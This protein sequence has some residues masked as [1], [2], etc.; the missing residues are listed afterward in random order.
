MKKFLLSLAFC[1]SLPACA[2]ELANADAL[3][4]RKAYP[5]AMRLYTKLGNAGNPVAQLRLGELYLNANAGSVDE[6]KAAQ[7]LSKAATKGNADAGAALA[8]LKTR[9]ARRADIDYWTAKYDG[10]DIVAG[11]PVCRVPR[12]PAMS[13]QNEEI[14]RIGAA[15]EKWQACYNTYA[16][17]LNDAGPLGKRMPADIAALLS[18]GEMAQAE[19]RYTSTIQTMQEDARVSA[20]LALADIAAWRS[21]TNAYVAEHNAIV[22]SGPSPERIRELEARK[23]NYASGGK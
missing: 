6:D 23:A 18:P 14:D 5:E 17:R 13:K 16:A 8:R 7:W 19:T 21:A 2:D 3:L 10:A 12:L 22:Q 1:L 4:A 15:I 11:M 9:A 20:K